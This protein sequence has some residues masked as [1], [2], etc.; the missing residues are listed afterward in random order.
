M[1]APDH[2]HLDCTKDTAGGGSHRLP[3]TGPYPL[4]AF[5]LWTLWVSTAR[6]FNVMILLCR[7]RAILCVIL[8]SQICLG[9]W[10]LFI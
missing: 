5:H 3:S 2:R 8:V 4:Q 10:K 6:S 7:T 1:Q 9:V